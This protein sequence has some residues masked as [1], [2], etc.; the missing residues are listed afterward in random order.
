[1]VSVN[2]ILGAIDLSTFNKNMFKVYKENN[3]LDLFVKYYGNYFGADYL[4]IPLLASVKRFLYA[5]TL[6]EN[7][8]K[9]FYCLMNN[10]LRSGNPKKICRYLPMISNIHRLIKYKYLNTYCVDVYRATYFKKELIDEIKTGK[11]MMNVSLWSSSKKLSVA[12]K[13]LFKYRKNILLHTIAK[14]GNNVDIHLEKLSKYPKEE[15]I[16]ILPFCFFEIKSFNKA[17]ENG[18]E[19]YN[20]ELI[21]CEEENQNNLVENVPLNTFK[22]K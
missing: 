19:F 11:K 18:L 7:N 16:L 22:L 3:C 14:E 2:K 12:K 4:M 17:K 9:S 1:M 8:G 21:Y 6:E 10:D 20:L 15:E 5:Y 13:F